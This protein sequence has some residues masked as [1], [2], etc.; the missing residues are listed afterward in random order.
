MLTTFPLTNATPAATHI[1]P[2]FF[3]FFP[4]FNYS[5]T[6]FSFVRGNGEST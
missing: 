6:C 1:I 2:F 5:F 3:P 4:L